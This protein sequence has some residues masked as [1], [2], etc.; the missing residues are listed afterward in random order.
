MA[1]VFISSIPKWCGECRSIPSLYL[2][3]LQDFPVSY[4]KVKQTLHFSLLKRVSVFSGFAAEIILITLTLSEEIT[5]VKV[6]MW[7]NFYTIDF[8]LC[9]FLQVFSAWVQMVPVWILL[10]RFFSCVCYC[11]VKDKIYSDSKV[12]SLIIFQLLETTSRWFEKRCHR[13]LERGNA[14]CTGILHF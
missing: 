9:W 5:M 11:K 12:W 8:S 6:V 14:I 4:R 10:L 1:V 3:V 2:A 13:F 7:I